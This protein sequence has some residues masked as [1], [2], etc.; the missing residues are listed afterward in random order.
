MIDLVPWDHG[1]AAK[2]EQY[3]D[4]VVAIEMVEVETHEGTRQSTGNTNLIGSQPI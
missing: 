3:E 2:V 1:V 4:K